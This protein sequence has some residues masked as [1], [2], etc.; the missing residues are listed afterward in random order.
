LTPYGGQAHPQPQARSYTTVAA[1][2]GPGSFS[3]YLN[4]GGQ[5]AR[6]GRGP[7]Q[8]GLA[9]QL[10]LSPQQRAISAA[11]P[12]PAKQPE[13]A[14][15]GPLFGERR[16]HT[17][18]RSFTRPDCATSHVALLHQTT[19]VSFRSLPHALH[20]CRRLPAVLLALCLQ[21]DGRVP[22]R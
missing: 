20:P 1:S 9:Q 3:S 21:H 2:A 17:R 15:T 5:G 10:G 12:L 7:A 13:A 8:G 14:D 18:S 4:G 16:R 19:D 11:V 22:A 6:L